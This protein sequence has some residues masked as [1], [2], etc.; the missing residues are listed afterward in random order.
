[1]KCWKRSSREAASAGG[2]CCCG[3]VQLA[4]GALRGS[5]SPLPTLAG[6]SVCAAPTA[7]GWA[8][9]DPVP[10]T[11]ALVSVPLADR[12]S[13]DTG[14]DRGRTEAGQRKE[15]PSAHGGGSWMSGLPV[16]KGWHWGRVWTAPGVRGAGM[17]CCCHQWPILLSQWPTSL[18]P[19]SRRVQQGASKQSM[20]CTWHNRAAEKYP[21]WKP[22]PLSLMAWEHTLLLCFPTR[23]SGCSLQ[24]PCTR[25]SFGKAVPS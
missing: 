20:R 19:G 24:K 12:E 13:W 8:C 21:K 25:S 22:Q 6:G 11:F 17:L 7:Q 2:P 10:W 15:C 18:S 5:N 9:Q 3:R 1:M 16:E 4:P 14:Q 23:W